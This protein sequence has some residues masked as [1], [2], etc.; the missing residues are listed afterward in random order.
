MFPGQLLL[1]GVLLAVLLP[2]GY[3]IDK[4]A[5]QRGFRDGQM[6]VLK[7]HHD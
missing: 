4:S 6:D 3:A 1:V 5:Y 2:I 7:R